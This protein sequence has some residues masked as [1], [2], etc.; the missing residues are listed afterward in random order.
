M[1]K[2]AAHLIPTHWDLSQE[3][4]FKRIRPIACKVVNP[5]LHFVAKLYSFS[6]NT[7]FILR[8][9]APSEDDKGA[10][11]A[12]PRGTAQKH[13]E[14]YIGKMAE[15]EKII[16]RDY[17]DVPYRRDRFMIVG[18]NE[19][20]VWGSNDPKKSRQE[21]E[22]W[23]AEAIH[24]TVQLVIYTVNLQDRCHAALIRVGAGNISVGWPSNWHVVSYD[25]QNFGIPDSPPDWSHYAPIREKILEG[26]LINNAYWPDLW[27][28]H[29]YWSLKGPEQLWGWWAGRMLKC[30]W[31]DVK[32]GIGES[33]LERRVEDGNIP[34]EQAGWTGNVSAQVYY[35][36]LQR[37]ERLMSQDGRFQWHMPFTWDFSKPF[38]SMDIRPLLGMFQANAE[39]ERPGNGP[40]PPPPPPVDQFALRLLAAGEEHQVIQF[41]PD[42][43]L[44][45]AIFKDNFVPNS[46]EFFIDNFVA[47]RAEHLDT[48]Q[49]R[50]YY[51]PVGQWHLVKY[52][53]R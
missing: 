20:P 49:V 46:G 43:A 52:V 48:G 32:Y 7:L 39:F 25:K 28:A 51:V 6:P 53:Q 41:N 2:T 15:L 50:I 45:R 22:L 16:K 19:P 11:I 13:A 35:D 27:I 8:E 31:K 30:P 37:Y 14:M 9:H 3:N 18:I 17:P 38:G 24:N 5:N 12:D 40:V 26:V 1:S 44:Q 4:H 33:G 29:E 42:A 21:Y 10:M 34:I 23:K 36:Q 47:Q